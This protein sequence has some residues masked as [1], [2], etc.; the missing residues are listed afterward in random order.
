[1]NE[2]IVITRNNTGIEIEVQFVDSKKK[3]IDTTGNT[4]EINIKDPKG[5]IEAF[6]GYHI[7]NS[8][9]KAGFMLETNNTNLEGL[10]SMYWS[11]IDENGYVT[12]QE[13]IY[14]FIIPENGGD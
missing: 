11:L 10:W 3:P 7:N 8:S 1:M 4:I 13:A 6:Q 14:Y 9:G 5:N 12:A 2:Q